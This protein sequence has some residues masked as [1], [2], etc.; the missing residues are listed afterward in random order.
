MALA[1]AY[2]DTSVMVK[3]YVLEPSSTMARTLLRRYRCLSSAILPVE[4]VS[5]LNRRRA[6]GDLTAA[7]F[8]LISSRLAE[9]RRR[10]E[11]VPVTGPLLALAEDLI[12]R[13]L[14]RTLD[15]IHLAAAL[16]FRDSSGMRVPFVTADAR[17][18]EAAEPAGLSI[19]W[20]G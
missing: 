8:A 5:A 11:L 15:A 16:T 1:F 9:D 2:F 13:H 20:V 6:V 4:L 14:L 18:R 19:L 10:W 3:R 7:D 17:Q 12:H